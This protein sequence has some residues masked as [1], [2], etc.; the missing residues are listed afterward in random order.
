MAMQ[1]A[2]DGDTSNPP[3]YRWNQW[4]PTAEDLRAYPGT[5]TGDDVDVT[6]YV[7]LEDDRVVMASRGMATTELAPQEQPDTFRI[8]GYLVRFHHNEAGRITQLTL[9]ATRVKGMRYTRQQD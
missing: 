7:T 4:T 1:I 3:Y 9:D 2:E 5:Y 6:L 8:P